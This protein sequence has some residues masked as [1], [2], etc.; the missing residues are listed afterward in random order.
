[1]VGVS[2]SG[3]CS[4]YELG[5]LFPARNQK[6][7]VRTQRIKN[8]FTFLKSICKVGV[9]YLKLLLFKVTVENFMSELYS[10]K[11]SYLYKVLLPVVPLQRPLGFHGS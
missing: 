11:A 7:R 10:E 8:V 9:L 3:T 1:M 5:W 4:L 6:Q 2:P